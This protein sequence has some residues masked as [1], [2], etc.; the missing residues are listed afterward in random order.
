LN[1]KITVLNDF[2]KMKLMPP[3]WASQIEQ[4]MKALEEKLKYFESMNIDG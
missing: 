2:E 4:A 1:H 3:M